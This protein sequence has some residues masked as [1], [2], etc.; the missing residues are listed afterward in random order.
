[1]NS[2]DLNVRSLPK[3][4]TLRQLKSGEASMKNIIRFL[5]CVFF[6][7]MA[8]DISFA[9]EQKSVAVLPF[10]VHSAENIE[11]VRLGI[12]DM[13]TS[14]IAVQDKIEVISKD[15]VLEAIKDVKDKELALSDVYGYGKK[16]NVDFVVWGSITK[17]G[18]N[19]SI[20]GTLLDIAADKAA[21]SIFAQ[22]QGMDE[23]IPKINDFAQR[24]DQYIL[25]AVPSTFSKAPAPAAQVSSPP[26]QKSPQAAREAEVIAGMKTS[27]KGTFTSTINPDFINTAQTGAPVNRKGFWMS[28]TYPTSFK[29][30][31]IGDVNHDGLNETVVIDDRSIMI[32]QKKGTEFNMIH[33]IAGKARDTYLTVDVA[34]I[35]GNGTPEIIVTSTNGNALNS[36][37]LEYVDGK[38]VEIASN[39]PWFLRVIN[40]ASEPVLLGQQKGLDD[41]FNTPI[42]EIVWRNGKYQEGRRMQIPLGLAIY[43]LT[44]ENIGIGGSEKVLAI[45]EYDHLGVYEPTTKNISR[46]EVFMGS[47]EG[48]WKTEETFGGSNNHLDVNVGQTPSLT[49]T[50]VYINLRILTADLNKDGKKEIIIV[51]NSSPT[52]NYFSNVKVY[53]SGEVYNLEWDGVSLVENWKTGKIN[54]YIADYQLK[55][56]DNDGENE[57]VLAV[58][59]S[60]TASLKGRSILASYKMT[61]Q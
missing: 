23:V 21:V 14:R 9:K 38:Y 29:G 52:G 40:I 50:S 41:T 42:Y 37:I 13:L 17:I 44:I 55:D 20:D 54:G 10:S 58:V 36:F 32:F 53:T 56:L 49:A 11:Y 24:I 35:N 19:I 39:L 51:R 33:T 7:V 34:D 2:P 57:I 31:D 46:I 4:A 26:E 6:L 15:A 30:M 48:L 59:V 61:A 1:L 28:Q 43:G 47:K 60:S 25:G 45:D 27:K 16:A 18:N 8:K 3:K 22:S 12:W 5:L